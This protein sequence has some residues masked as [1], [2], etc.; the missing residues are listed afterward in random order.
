MLEDEPSDAELTEG[1]LRKAGLVFSFE[2][3]GTRDGFIAALETFR[4]D[5]ILADYRLPAFNG[6]A[7]LSIAHEQAPDVPLIL[8]SGAMADELAVEI[9]KAGAHDYILKDRLA[10]LPSAVRRA[11]A[12]ADAIR[13]RRAA[14]KAL[15]ES[16]EK[17]RTMTASAQDAIIL[18]D[19]DARISFWNTAAERIFGLS[20]S[21]V[22]GKDLIKLFVPERLRACYRNVL[23]KIRDTHAGS[24]AGKTVELS[25]NR[26]DGSEFPLE[27][28]IA[29]IV[30]DDKWHAICI[31]RDISERNRLENE[32][33]Q[34]R[35]SLEQQV[36]LKTAELE[37]LNRSLREANRELADAKC[38]F[39]ETQR[40][41]S[42]EQLAGGVAHEINN[43][44][45]FVSTNLS[46]L[47]RYF[48]EILFM[49]EKEQPGRTALPGTG[50]E[51]LDLDEMKADADALV[52]ESK[53]G[54]SRIKKIIQDL[55]GFASTSHSN[56]QHFDLHDGLEA[57]L[58]LLQWRITNAN[59]IRDYGQIPAIW[60]LPSE[61]NLV[62]MNLLLN[63]SEAITDHGAITVRTRADDGGVRVEMIDT[64]C[65]IPEDNL[66][67]V[68]DPF[69]TTMPIGKGLGLGLSLSYG[70]ILRH[71]GR[72]EVTSTVGKGSCFR[73]WLPC[74]QD[75]DD[76]E[77][78]SA[79]PGK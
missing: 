45:A 5:I 61:I 47:K 22:F 2:R 38:Q 15:R 40:M 19:S 75:G 34:Y 71:H 26:H 67:R 13:Q 7:A 77:T 4:P 32:L 33:M 21:E 53:D 52:A 73:I 48:D 41:E 28:S 66:Q 68:F 10:R 55:H 31:A 79:D 37:H 69:F 9:L 44:I 56:W 54:L 24:F 57:T 50:Q 6:M 65:G 78:A 11:L 74:R 64:G 14:E 49:L 17:F 35:D 20:E 30:L 46:T 72:I 8:V 12:E 63:A 3:V 23:E 18:V 60:C 51:E 39:M 43:P 76:G 29:A 1:V 36:A 27:V 62:F 42:L 16:E 70:I 25:A 59:I 58:S